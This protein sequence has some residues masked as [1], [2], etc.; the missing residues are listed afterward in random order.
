MRAQYYEDIQVGD[1]YRSPGRTVTEADVVAFA[2]RSGDFTE[3]HTNA[4]AMREHVYGARIAHG[5]L[6]L[7]IQSGLG[8]RVIPPSHIVGFAGITDWRFQAPIFIGD[9][10]HLEITVSAKRQSKSRPDRG[11][12]SY[13]RRLVNQHK[14]V[15][16]SGTTAN[17]VLLTPPDAEPEGPAG[18]GPD[19]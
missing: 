7:A 2:G 9:T 3:L 19:V 8:T 14:L 17:V 12:V 11:I 13:E 16:Q 6:G 10:V 18:Q 5:L 15:V 4:E 1:S